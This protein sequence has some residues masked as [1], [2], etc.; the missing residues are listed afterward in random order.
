M[1]FLINIILIG[2][3]YLSTYMKLDIV[4]YIYVKC[5][6]RYCT[7]IICHESILDV[8]LIQVFTCTHVY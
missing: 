5:R 6:L 8:K 2:Q 1:Y 7:M 4:S 3:M